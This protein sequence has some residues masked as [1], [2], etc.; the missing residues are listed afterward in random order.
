VEASRKDERTAY[1]ALDLH[2][3]DDFRSLIFR[4]NDGGKTFTKITSGLPEKGWVWTVREDPKNPDLLYAGTELGLYA[5]W[6][7]G[8]TWV[9]LHLANMPYSIAVRDILIHPETNDLIVATHG[10]SVYILDDIAALQHLNGAEQLFAIRPAYR[11][12]VRATHFAV[13]DKAFAAPNPPYGALITYFLPE[14][15]D[16]KL[17][18]V[19]AK[20][21]MVRN[22]R[23]ATHE[24]GINRVAWDLH[25]E[26]ARGPQ[27]L[28]GAYKIRL[29]ANGKTFEQTLQLKMDPNV[30]VSAQ[31]LAT[32]FDYARRIQQLQ[33][34]VNAAIRKID[35][36]GTPNPLRDK[37]TRPEGAGRSETGPRL[38]ENLTSLFTLVS[39]PDAA[40]TPAMIAYFQE[41]NGQ[42]E[43]LL[44]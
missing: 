38:L 43:S 22:L 8:T 13:G 14:S 35:E 18:V 40:P 30:T 33:A 2:M 12:A 37:L 20:G 5:S 3:F 34:R 42:V 41:L 1:V 7:S 10:R 26:S 36:S 23:D 6:N 16:V 28:P 27:A 32:Q 9:P 39:A 4:T 31:D 15:A 44:K 11:H 21:A 24:A 19:D 29:T 25:Y 17:E